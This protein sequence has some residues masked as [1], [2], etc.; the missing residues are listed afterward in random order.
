MKNKGEYRGVDY[1]TGRFVYGELSLVFGDPMIE[2]PAGLVKLKSGTLEKYNVTT[3]NYE[4]VTT[5]KI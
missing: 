5:W 3:K 1:V 2:I 4:K